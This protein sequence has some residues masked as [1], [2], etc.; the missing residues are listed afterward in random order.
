MEQENRV[1]EL[2]ADIVAAHVS[3]NTVG[4]DDVANL[5]RQVYQALSELGGYSKET[6][7][8]EKPAVSIRSSVK[9][10]HLVC[11]AC[12]SRQKTLRRHIAVAHGLTPEEYRARYGLPIPIR[13]SRPTTPIGGGRSPARSALA[14]AAAGSRNRQRRESRPP[15]LGG[16]AVAAERPRRRR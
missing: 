11:L 9:R 14:G 2:A 10:D 12:G 4:V 7:E 1:L 6:V 8:E 15:S 16:A 3:N 5:V 13:W